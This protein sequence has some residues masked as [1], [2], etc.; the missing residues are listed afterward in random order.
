MEKQCWFCK[1]TEEF[2]LKQKEELLKSIEQEISECEKNEKSIFDITKEKLGFTDEKKNKVRE[3][4]QEYSE[5]TLNA[6]LEN[7]QSFIRL[8][9]NLGIVLEYFQKYINCNSKFVKDVIEQFLLEPIES[10]Y[11]HELR[12]NKDKKT[13]LLQRKEQLESI[14]TFFIEKEITPQSLDSEIRELKREPV[15]YHR[16]YGYQEQKNNKEKD[17]GFSYEKLGF[18][19]SKKIFICPFCLSLFADSA[20]ASFDIKEAQKRAQYDAYMDDDGGEDDDFE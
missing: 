4:R 1:N 11:A 5:M 3:I 13:Q 16:F 7:K 10:R 17:F 14:K 6:V 8:E 15:E 20:N 12:Q 18:N 19:F 2:F 9:P